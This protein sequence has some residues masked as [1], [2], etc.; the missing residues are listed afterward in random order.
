MSL[1]TS[2]NNSVM[3]VKFLGTFPGLQ[4]AEKLHKYFVDGKRGR[5][6]FERTLVEGNVRNLREGRKNVEK[7]DES[8]L[9][10]YMGIAEDL[11]EV[12]HDT[13]RR[14]LI[15]SRKEIQDFENAP[16]YDS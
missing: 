14:C 13:K 10:G 15:R 3:L 4:E 2:P 1:G 9:Y 16:I 6:G 7:L 5:T 8:A 12:D 11:D